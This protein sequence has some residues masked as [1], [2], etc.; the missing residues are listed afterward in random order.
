V[1]TRINVISQ[2]IHIYILSIQF[3]WNSQVSCSDFGMLTAI[4]YHFN[5]TSDA[6]MAT[7]PTEQIYCEDLFNMRS[8]KLTHG[9]LHSVSSNTYTN[10][11]TQFLEAASQI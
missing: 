9:Q 7:Y 6:K 1:G 5:D 11:T 2:G 3:C 8:F 10:L 4:S